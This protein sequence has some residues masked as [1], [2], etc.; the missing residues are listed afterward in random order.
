[1]R[2]DS[3]RNVRDVR[4]VRNVLTRAFYSRSTLTVAEELL[5]KVLVHRTAAGDAAGIIVETEVRPVG[6]RR[7]TDRPVSHMST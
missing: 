1:M 2:R 3:V 4:D 5:G 7:S 6:T